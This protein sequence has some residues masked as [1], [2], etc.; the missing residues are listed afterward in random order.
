VPPEEAG[1]LQSQL[2]DLHFL[3]AGML[4]NRKKIDRAGELLNAAERKALDATQRWAAPPL[5]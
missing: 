2:R 5:A 3:E 4:D 1:R